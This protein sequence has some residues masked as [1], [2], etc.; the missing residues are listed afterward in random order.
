M[1]KRIKINLKNLAVLVI[2][3][4]AAYV[5]LH[6]V[7]MLSI[8]SWINKI[9]VSW[10]WFGLLTWIISIAVLS[11]CYDYIDNYQK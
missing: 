6:D 1:K 5:I 10:T 2:A 9:T 4:I 3:T 8:Y 7:Y 11:L